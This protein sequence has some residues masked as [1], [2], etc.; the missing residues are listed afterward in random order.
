[1]LVLTPV[2]FA[3]G[4]ADEQEEEGISGISS[5]RHLLFPAAPSRFPRPL[6]ASP[7]PSSLVGVTLIDS[8]LTILTGL[9]VVAAADP[10]SPGKEEKGGRSTQRGGNEEKEGKRKVSIL[11]S[12]TVGILEPQ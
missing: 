6:P 11:G 12:F 10:T 3:C 1:M 7:V 4:V 5:G 9:V 8:F 2:A